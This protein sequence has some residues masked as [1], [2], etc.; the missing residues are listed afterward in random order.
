[1]AILAT[2]NSW[3]T[4]DQV[5]AALLNS[6]INSSTFASGAVDD[7]TTELNGSN[8]LI[9]K[10]G[11]VTPAKLSTGAPSWDTLGNLTVGDETNGTVVSRGVAASQA[12]DTG[13]TFLSGASFGSGDGSVIWAFGANHPSRPGW[14]EFLADSATLDWACRY[15]ADQDLWDFQAKDITTTGTAS[16]GTLNTATATPAS[17]SA[18]GTAGDMAWDASYIYICTATD[19]WKR[20]AIST[21]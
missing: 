12:G 10:D 20:V 8:Q 5:T 19:T 21:W 9:V 3:S 7:S 16:V 13:A 18:T 17:A 2:G 4:G 1:M 14:I 11:G 6:A 15:K